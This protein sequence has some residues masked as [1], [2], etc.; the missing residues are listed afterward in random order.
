MG[1]KY[2][3]VGDALATKSDYENG[4]I[5]YAHIYENS[6]SRFGKEIGK[7]KDLKFIG[8]VNAKP[9]VGVSEM[10]NNFMEYF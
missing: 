1:K 2:I 8:W 7:T 10:I 9:K 5:S 3:R 6:I 4:K